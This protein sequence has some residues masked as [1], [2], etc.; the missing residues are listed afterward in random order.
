MGHIRRVGEDRWEVFFDLG[1]DPVTGKRRQR[2]RT[3]RGSEARARVELENIENEIRYGGFVDPSTM[4]VSDLATM[5]LE[6]SEMRV[7]YNTLRSY[8]SKLSTHVMPH[9]GHRKIRAVST[10]VVNRLYSDL[11][12]KH[13]VSAATVAGVH[14]VLHGM[15]A[16][17]VKWRL[18]DTNP[19]SIADP[20][21]VRKPQT[22][23]WTQDEAIAFFAWIGGDPACDPPRPRDPD[24]AL[25]WILTSTGMRLGEVLALHRSSVDLDERFLVVERALTMAAGGGWYEDEPKTSR[26]R[27]VVTFGSA[28]A[29]ILRQHI[30][31]LDFRRM[32]AA[33]WTDNDLV[34]PRADG[35]HMI[36]TSVSQRWRRI[37]KAVPGVKPIR[38][39]DARHTSATGLI[40]KGVGG[41]VVSER[42]GHSAEAFTLGR[43]VHRVDALH[44]DAA[45]AIDAFLTG[46][47][48]EADDGAPNTAPNTESDPEPDD[49]PKD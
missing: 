15:F 11:L 40:A 21:R 1:P 23:T 7:R 47:D 48:P 16:A 46:R 13:K 38:L 35:S 18:L 33:E 49:A 5:W 19:V 42:L 28:T 6:A 29:S 27:R 3:V 37:V 32:V 45:Q 17:A 24:F 14:R 8:Q 34:F 12:V 30:E 36:P 31:E 43:Y 2:S 22:E 44:R 39:H 26:G 9:I 41:K 20:P 25:W 4:T 10:P